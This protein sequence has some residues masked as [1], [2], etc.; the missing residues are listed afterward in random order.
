MRPVTS[1]PNPSNME[2]KG[3]WPI[4]WRASGETVLNPH[5]ES[6]ASRSVEDWEAKVL[7]APGAPQR[8]AALEAEMRDRLRRSGHSTPYHLTVEIE[9]SESPERVRAEVERAL[10]HVFPKVRV[11]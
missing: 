4:S 1:T 2:R 5:S 3:A 7:A 6:E 8:V 10:A 11:G 9:S